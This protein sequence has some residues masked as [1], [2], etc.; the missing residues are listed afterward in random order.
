MRG[1]SEINETNENPHA[2]RDI[3][4]ARF[5]GGADFNWRDHHVDPR[6]AKQ[7]TK[8]EAVV[9]GIFPDIVIDALVKGAVKTGFRHMGLEGIHSAIDAKPPFIKFWQKLNDRRP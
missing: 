9:A 7:P 8:G 1:I 2:P 6:A 5:T 3:P 4:G